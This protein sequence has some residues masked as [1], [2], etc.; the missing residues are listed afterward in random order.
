[1]KQFVKKFGLLMAM[2]LTVL[3]AQ[4]YDFEVNG[5]YYNVVSLEEMTCEVTYK[6]DSYNSYIGV[7]EIPTTTI[8]KN[9]RFKVERIGYSAFRDCANLKR[10]K[11]PESITEI[12]TFAFEDCKTLQSISLPISLKCIGSYVFSGCKNLKEIVIPSNVDELGDC[13]FENSGV[14]RCIISDSENPII[15]E[16]WSGSPNAYDSFRDTRIRELYIGRSFEPNDPKDYKGNYVYRYFSPF[17]SMVT[18]EEVT[19]GGSVNELPLCSFLASEKKND[20]IINSPLPNL[21]KFILKQGDEDLSLIKP[22]WMYYT[23]ENGFKN[24]EHLVLERKIDRTAHF[25]NVKIVVI[26][27]KFAEIDDF[28]F[29]NCDDLSSVEIFSNLSNIG[30]YAFSRTKNLYQIICHAETPPA[31]KGNSGFSDSQFLKANIYV[32]ESSIENYKA[33][34]VWKDFWNI[35]KLSDYSSIVSVNFNESVTFMISN[36]KIVVENIPANSTIRVFNL[37]GE[38]LAETKEP[39]INGLNKGIYIV[40]VNGKSFKVAI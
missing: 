1:M 39:I 11:I 25:S 24:I 35:N 34:N 5:I 38:L 32:P 31:F 27:G 17:R 8:Y 10:I 16:C 20:D 13:V 14:E 3:T 19:I 6:D 33:A 22:E 12:E 23:S 2:L 9:K 29:M 37:N 26:S 18:L 40:S 28:Q 15:L 21:K 36:G 4:A 7:I 30:E